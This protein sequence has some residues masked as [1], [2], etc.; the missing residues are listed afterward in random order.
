MQK[1]QKISGLGLAA[2]H[3]TKRR[4]V[5]LDMLRGLAALGVVVGHVRGFIV[6]DY[7]VANAQSAYPMLVQTVYFVTGLGHQCVIAFFA[8]SGFL[9]GG[10]ALLRILEDDWHWSGYMLRRLSR[11]WMVLIPALLLT[12]GLDTA[13]QIM[14]GRAG[15]EGAFY[16]LTNSGPKPSTPA[17]LS[18]STLAGNAFFL[19]TVIVPTFGSNG[20]LWSLANEFWY[21]VAFPLTFVALFGKRW[22]WMRAA[23]GVL[24]IGL[25]LFLPIEMALL[26]LIW[27]AG[28]I[29]YYALVFVS[30][31]NNQNVWF[32]WLGFS[33]LA[34]LGS[35]V[36]DRL[37]PGIPS[38]II[39]GIAFSCLLPGLV[40]IPSFGSMYNRLAVYLAKI[41]YTLYAT[42]F[43]VLAFIWFVMLAPHQWMIGSTTAI[44]VAFL[45]LTTLI[46]ATAMWWLFE[47]NT[48]RL[49]KV[50]ETWLLVRVVT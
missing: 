35:I 33:F 6:V 29:A 17:D 31:P 32:I 1:G 30:G 21:Y 13:G 48:E 9:V 36:L 16:D 20:P 26:G 47:R 19:Q 46:A 18:L 14:G 2:I 15:Y 3:K 5:H 8:L 22:G 11:L 10:P 25:A 37:W 45:I 24:G 12:L 40:L 50:L 28:A 49:R 23:M 38:D 7:S 41:S 27:V 34:V 44:L 39:L 4:S 42:H 43:P